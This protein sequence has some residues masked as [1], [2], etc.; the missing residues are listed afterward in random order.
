MSFVQF[1]RIFWARRLL[2]G[3]A[4][5]ASLLG[6]L[7]LIVILPPRWE[8]DARVMLNLIKP[9]PVTGDVLA[10]RSAGTYVASQTALITD[11]SVA[12]QVV[13][14]LGWLT[15]P[16]LIETYQRRSKYD[17]RDFRRWLA[18]QVIDRTKVKVVEGSN[19][20]E[21]SY[22]ATRP[23][24]AKGVAEA[25]RQAYIDTSVAFR[26]DDAT[27]NAEWYQTQADA[28]QAAL[29]AAEAAKA[30]YERQNGIVMAD[31]NTDLDSARLRALASQGVAAP[32]VPPPP[33]TSSA[34]SVQLA[35]VDAQIAEAARTLGPNHPQMQQL[36][37]T[38]A[39]LA[40]QVAQEQVAAR[41]QAGAAATAAVA[42]AGAMDRAVQVIRSR[43][44]GE[45]DKLGRLAQL[46]DEVILRRDQFQK[47]SQRAAELRQEALAGDAGLTPLGPAS[48]PSSPSF[49]NKLLIIPGSVGLGLVTGILLALII[50]LISRRVRGLED[51]RGTQNLPVL[52]V[53]AGPPKVANPTLVRLLRQWRLG[54]RRLAVRN[55]GARL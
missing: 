35:Q 51:L 25:L 9:D 22:T 52:A 28:A 5:A 27:R 7:A 6:A 29:N 53:I 46:Q 19:I 38:R 39:S 21:I 13:D 45:S 1:L 2:I 33:L 41:A 18:Q 36:R 31:D 23:S 17:T 43:V 32:V 49:P 40:Q 44:V 11:Y 48:T 3:A 15:D 4:T 10:G 50:E 42:S 12:G 14:Q 30:D 37:A 16:R 55:A 47:T 54:W 24:D 34:A 26:R 8:A 20:L